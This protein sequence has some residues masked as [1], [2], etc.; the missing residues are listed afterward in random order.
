MSVAKVAFE[1][2]TIKVSLDLILPVRRMK[3]PQRR[4]AGT[5]GF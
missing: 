4:S 5:K 1:M 2:K 3:N